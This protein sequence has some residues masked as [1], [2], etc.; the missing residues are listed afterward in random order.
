M[1][2]FPFYNSPESGHTE[3]ECLYGTNEGTLALLLAPA[4]SYADKQ[5]EEM[6]SWTMQR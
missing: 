1:G 5:R 6:A 2:L 4:F 3:C